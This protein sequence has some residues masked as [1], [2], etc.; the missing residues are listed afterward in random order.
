MRAFNSSAP[1]KAIIAGEHSVVYGGLA[2]A[3]P[4]DNR[5]RCMCKVSDAPKGKGCIS[6]EDIVGSGK[7]FPD[8]R[9]EDSDGWFGAKAKLIEFVLE[10]EERDI[11]E[12]KIALTLS[13]NNIPKG[14]GH[15]AATAAA[16]SLCI[17]GALGIKPAK[18]RLFE[19]MQAFEAVA[20]GGRPSGVDAMAVLSDSP[21]EFRRRFLADG[22]SKLDFEGVG[23]SLPR[24]TCILL[25][26]TLRAGE[27]PVTTAGMIR[28][29][30]ETEN[31][32]KAPHELSEDARLEI[33]SPFDELVLDIRKE[34]H[35]KGNPARLGKLLTKNHALLREAGVSS[36]G[37]EETLD[38]ANR[39]GALGGKL[40]GAGGRGGAAL[41]YCRNKEAEGILGALR[42]NGIRGV[43][44]EFST[45]GACLE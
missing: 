5:K 13:K 10:S 23:L 21:L 36:I 45:R 3:A 11:G 39:S 19:A 29:F 30:A 16:M 25:A 35:E 22:T 12:L 40:T 18:T 32:P 43:K 28:K 1:T 31:I 8:G 37:I 33:T 14:T 34:M 2:L 17:Y 4:L 26:N 6:V 42:E 15:S 20:H 44:A 41:I 27:T 24:G 38:I 7:Y 9:Y